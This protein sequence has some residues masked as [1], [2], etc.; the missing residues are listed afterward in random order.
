MILLTQH[1]RGFIVLVLWT[2]ILWLRFVNGTPAE[3][4]YYNEQLIDHVSNDYHCNNTWSQRYYQSS[5]YFRGPGSPIFLVLGGESVIEPSTGLIY[6]FITDHLAKYFGA[7]V[8]QPE[9]RFYGRSQPIPRSDIAYALSNGL[10]D[11]RIKLLT[12]EQALYDAVQLVQHVR[13]DE[14]NC[15]KDPFS[16][17]YCPIIAVGGSYSG[18][19]SAMARIMF[20]HIIDISYSGSAPMKFY[21]QQTNPN[22][23]YNHITHVAEDAVPGCSKAVKDTLLFVQRQVPTFRYINETLLGICSNTIPIYAQRNITIFLQELFMMV[24]YSF[25]NDNMAYYPPSPDRKLVKACRIFMDTNT[26]PFKRLSKYLIQSLGD[27]A[28]DNCFNM[29]TQLPAGANAT[30]SGGDWSGVSTGFE[31]DSWDFQTCT[32]LVEQISFGP[33]SMFP[34]RTWT[35]DWLI[36]HCAMRFNDVVP[37]PYNLNQRWKINDLLLSN[38]SYIL[39]TNGLKDGWS[40]GGIQQNLSDNVVAINF[41][42]GAHHSDLSHIGPTVNDTSDI[43]EGFRRIRSLFALWLNERKSG[44]PKYDDKLKA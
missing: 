37:Q 13:Y 8:L 10:P 22:A 36:H 3:P 43:Q 29:S 20:P 33:E 18:F 21:S 26:S 23:Y 1:I 30:I 38:T 44:I 2:R 42:N 27:K 39:F 24:G 17:E 16:E 7:F 11:P 14:L 15:S 5:Q 40:V 32:L 35:F 9:H 6:P 34:V 25:A 41:P 12:Y 4:Y 28:D 31:G 19:L